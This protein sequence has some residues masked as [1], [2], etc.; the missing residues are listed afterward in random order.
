MP[1]L[2]A[3]YPHWTII[4]WSVWVLAGLVLE[5]V[6]LKRLRRAIPLTWFLR[7]VLPRWLVFM[8]L[9]WLL[10]HFGVETNQYQPPR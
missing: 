10:Y 6:G 5:V 9:G 7:D 1:Y 8:L 3:H 2:W 4:A